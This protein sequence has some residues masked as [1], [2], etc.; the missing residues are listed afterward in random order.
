MGHDR[1][2]DCEPVHNYVVCA[3]V[4]PPQQH[5]VCVSV[6]PPSAP[7][8][9]VCATKTSITVPLWA[10]QHYLHAALPV[11]PAPISPRQSRTQQL[12]EEC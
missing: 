5:R 9:T 12:W 11:A 6:S 10:E 1:F 3:S 8:N 2:S 7:N 4:S